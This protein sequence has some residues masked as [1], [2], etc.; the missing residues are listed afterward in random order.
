MFELKKVY[1]YYSRNDL[2]IIS[3][4]IEQSETSQQIQ[5]FLDTNFTQYGYELTW[6]FG[7][8]DGTIWE[9]Y[10]VGQGGIPALCIFDKK[11]KLYFS[12]EGLAVFSE[13]PQGYP[14]NLARLKPIIDEILELEKNE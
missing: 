7:K 13:I 9:K 6:I 12:H 11:G 2:E 5:S 8:D 14:A 1:D 3:I 4:D 10:K